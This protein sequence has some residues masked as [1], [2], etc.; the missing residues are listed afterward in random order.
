MLDGSSKTN[1]WLKKSNF[2]GTRPPTQ[3]E[4]PAKKPCYKSQNNGIV[5]SNVE[6]HHRHRHRHRHS[7]IH[8]T[9]SAGANFSTI[10]RFT[11]TAIALRQSGLLQITQSISQ[12]MKSNDVIQKEIDKLQK[13]TIEY[14]RRLHRE[15]QKK[16]EAENEM[17]GCCNQEGQLLLSKLSQSLL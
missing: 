10:G 11:R 14:S 1:E 17:N 13:E 9:N 12:L 4:S 15:L 2:N 16:L 6:S 7:S 5:K 3:D 8:K